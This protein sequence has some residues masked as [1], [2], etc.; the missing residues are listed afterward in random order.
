MALGIS[1]HL[2][3]QRPALGR[4]HLSLE[5]CY[6]QQSRDNLRDQLEPRRQFLVPSYASQEPNSFVVVVTPQ[7]IFFP[8]ICAALIQPLLMVMIMVLVFALVTSW[9]ERQTG[10]GDIKQSIVPQDGRVGARI[11]SPEDEHE[12][13]Q[14]V[15]RSRVYRCRG[16]YVGS[17][18]ANSQRLVRL[19]M[20][21]WTEEIEDGGVQLDAIIC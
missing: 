9:L 18:A 21:K 11:T 1:L 20:E 13:L 10:V 8:Y 4:R 19:L 6:A 2:S 12:M 15:H 3:H 14:L 7:S 17:E 16:P 5:Y